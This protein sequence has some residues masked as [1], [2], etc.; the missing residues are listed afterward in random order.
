MHQDRCAQSGRLSANRSKRSVGA[1]YRHSW[2]ALRGVKMTKRNSNR[3]TENEVAFA[4]IQI[5]KTAPS[6]IASFSRCRKEVPNYLNLQIADRANSKTRPGEEMWEQQI[7]N[8]KS[9]FDAPGNYIC[10]GYLRHVPK[11]GYEVTT[12]GKT[13]K[14]P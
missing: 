11:V 4:I 5:A 9:H 2:S 13:R 12:S 3:S 7:R 14:S 6:G 10:E 8:I 1:L